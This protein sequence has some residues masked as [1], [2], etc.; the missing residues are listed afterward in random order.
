[1]KETHFSSFTALFQP[2]TMHKFT[3]RSTGIILDLLDPSMLTTLRNPVPYPTQSPTGP[4]KLSTHPGIGSLK[5]QPTAFAIIN[6]INHNFYE[7]TYRWS[8]DGNRQITRF[9][10]YHIFSQILRKVVRIWERFNQS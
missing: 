10:L 2:A 8:H 3:E 4:L 7:Q 5:L 6:T 1:M 9:F